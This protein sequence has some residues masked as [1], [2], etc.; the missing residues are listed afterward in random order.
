MNDSLL[1]R[2]LNGMANIDEQPKAAE[3]GGRLF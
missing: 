1:M 2:V 3:P